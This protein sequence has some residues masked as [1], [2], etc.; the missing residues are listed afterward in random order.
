M[1]RWHK[2]LLEARERMLDDD[3][4]FVLRWVIGLDLGSS[5]N[6]KKARVCGGFC[7]EKSSNVLRSREELY[8]LL[9]HNYSVNPIF[10]LHLFHYR[11]HISRELFPNILERV[12]LHDSY[13]VRKRDACGLIGLSPHQKITFAL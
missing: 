2:K 5:L 9:M 7:S 8:N 1:H 13:F 3:D 12:C 11:Y 6:S 10:G 4:E